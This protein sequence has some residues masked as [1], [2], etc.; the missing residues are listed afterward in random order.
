MSLSRS[1]F[2]P[3]AACSSVIHAVL[4]PKHLTPASIINFCEPGYFCRISLINVWRV[5]MQTTSPCQNTDHFAGQMPLKL[6]ALFSN[7]D[8]LKRTSCCL[9]IISYVSWKE[10]VHIIWSAN[11]S[12][13][14]HNILPIHL[15]KY[16]DRCTA[17]VSEL[18]VSSA[19]GY[20]SIVSIRD[21]V[22]P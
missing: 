13:S 21:I 3:R 2:L 10:L 19:P 9:I 20:R 7:A 22:H 6:S 16:L 1:T 12:Y 8:S 5:I 17:V 11:L 15:G 4:Q 18:K 14:T